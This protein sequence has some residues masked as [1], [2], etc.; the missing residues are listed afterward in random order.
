MPLAS[1]LL[2]LPLNVLD[3]LEK[4]NLL[5]FCIHLRQP[6]IPTILTKMSGYGDL[7]GNPLGDVGTDLACR[8]LEQLQTKKSLLGARPSTPVPRETILAQLTEWTK[9]NIDHIENAVTKGQLKLVFFRIACS[10]A[11]P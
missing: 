4:L 6:A 3:G 9:A 1:S 10:I 2:S 11:D 5:I 7:L 8:H